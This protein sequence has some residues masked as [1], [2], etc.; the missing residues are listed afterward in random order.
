MLV[1]IST[2]VH[3]L[4]NFKQCHLPVLELDPWAVRVLRKPFPMPIFPSVPLCFLLVVSQFQV[5]LLRGLIYLELILCKM[6]DIDLVLSLC[7]G[8]TSFLRTLIEKDIFFL[9]YV[10]GSFMKNRLLAAVGVYRG[11]LF[12]SIGLYHEVFVTMALQYCWDCE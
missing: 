9:M 8:P 5:P 7:V 1:I 10:V 2:V 3:K 12:Y 11:P 4:V 6:S